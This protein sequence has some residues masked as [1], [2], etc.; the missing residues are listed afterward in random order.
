MNA[1]CRRLAMV[2]ACALFVGAASEAHAQVP[3]TTPDKRAEAQQ[4]FNLALTHFDREEWQAALVEFLKSR[5]LLPTKGNTK[6]AAICLRKVGRF[7][8]SL[9]MFE[10]LLRDFP[11]VAPA[12]KALAQKEI[13]ELQASVGTVTFEG[14]PEGASITVDGV[15]RGKAPL[16]GPLRLSAG[17]HAV[18]VTME[19]ALPFE[20]KLDLVGKQ[21]AVVKVTLARLTQAGRLKVTEHDGKALDVVVDGAV[22]GKTPWEGALAPGDHVALL[23]GEGK[24]G[25][26]PSAV[27]IT[28]DKVSSLDL[29]AE[30]LRGEARIEP[31][32]ASAS[33]T[34]DD[35]PVGRGTWEGRLRHGPHRIAATAD[36]YLPLTKDVSLAP[37]TRQVI[38]MAL[39]R[40]P[41]LVGGRPGIVLELD[42]AA[43]LGLVFGGDLDDRC[44][45]SCSAGL[46]IGFQGMLHGTYQLG[47]GLGFGV[48]A[49][50]LSLGRDVTG[51]AETITAPGRPANNGTLDESLRLGGLRAQLEGQYKA[52]DTWPV[53]LRL[54][55]GVLLGSLSDDRSGNFTDSKNTPYKVSTKQSPSATYLSISPEARIGRKLGQHFEVNVGVEVLVLT[56]LKKPEWDTSKTIGAGGD[57][58]G[59]FPS[60]SLAGGILVAA[61]PGL[62][63]KY[64]F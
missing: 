33:I 35:V 13:G 6:N 36:G 27:K 9:D 59:V 61:V 41:S 54:G 63:A 2:L 30:E 12:D 15:D 26:P 3:E 31:L 25:T 21:A 40:D 5:E 42:G 23:R 38:P 37:D 1:L 8:E 64:E 34:I 43:A 51:R 44:T 29:L 22:V 56:A 45:G 14:A 24:L 52:G 7:D 28:I 48:G 17:S 55:V 32:P 53:T 60:A 58:I 47:S 20:A 4:H 18:R 10:A 16:K 19:G 46:P 62:G 49:G 57:G 39:Q 11:D 50:Y